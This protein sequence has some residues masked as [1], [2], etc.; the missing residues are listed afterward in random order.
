VNPK[1]WTIPNLALLF[2][3]ETI[4]G[5]CRSE[6]SNRQR[7]RSTPTLAYCTNVHVPPQTAQMGLITRRSEVQI[8]P[9][10][11]LE[12]WLARLVHRAQAPGQRFRVRTEVEDRGFSGLFIGTYSPVPYAALCR[13]ARRVRP[14]RSAFAIEFQVDEALRR[15]A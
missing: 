6:A 15:A 12:R 9:P 8:L 2:G 5:R 10:P 3:R 4:L 13:V 11:P 1:A 7:C 14:I